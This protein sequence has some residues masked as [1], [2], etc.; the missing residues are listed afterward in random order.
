MDDWR[1][2][3]ELLRLHDRIRLR[4]RVMM[5][6]GHLARGRDPAR[7]EAAVAGQGA[8]DLTFAIDVPAEEE[9][10]RFARDFAEGGPLTV[11]SEG[12]GE[13]TYSS[14]RGPGPRPPLRLI[15]DPIDGTRNLMFDMRSAWILT[16]LADD[17]GSATTLADV[18]V[19]V[20]SELP[21]RDRKSYS[22][23]SA[24]KGGGARYERRDLESGAVLEERPLAP[25]P[26]SRLDNGFYVFFKFSPEDRVP[27]AEIEHDFLSELVRLHGVDRRTLYDDQYISN[28]GQL[29]L[30]MT[31]RYRMVAD[32]RGRIGDLL[33]VDNFTTKPYD[34]CCALIAAEAG[35]PV[36]DAFGKPLAAPLDVHHRVSF[37]GY[38]SDA[39][40][41]RLEP[42]LADAVDRFAT[43]ASARRA[44]PRAAP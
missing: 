7:G 10:D 40:R 39:V 12:A 42:L 30:L 27:L 22:I 18:R 1:L 23:L 31:Q 4:T 43:R 33:G 9:I 26:D 6:R 21:T 3:A 17:R 24:V 37:V 13:R 34:V 11:I 25:S 41:R 14:A 44:R 35:V 36:T 19:A 32:L 15:A 38:A 29:Y 2:A 20:Q 8:G 16:A 5:E 28:A